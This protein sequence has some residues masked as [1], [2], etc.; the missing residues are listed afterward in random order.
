MKPSTA[1][2]SHPLPR[3][4]RVG[5]NTG[6]MLVLGATVLLTGCANSGHNGSHANSARAFDGFHQ[7]PT[8]GFRADGVAGFVFEP[9]LVDT[10][11]E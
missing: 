2:V 8:S 4:A 10:E 3:A 7:V 1:P 11:A 6:L 5:I 9:R